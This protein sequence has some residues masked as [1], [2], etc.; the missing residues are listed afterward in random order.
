MGSENRPVL[1]KIESQIP[2]R[3]I[4]STSG[5]WVGVCEPLKLTAQAETWIDLVND[6]AWAME[7]VFEDLLETNDLETFLRE[8]G[9]SAPQLPTVVQSP[10]VKFD[11]PFLPQLASPG[12]DQAQALSL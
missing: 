10:Q 9:W 11:I 2:W 6:I 3:V 4:R 8:R 7:S 5:Y 1:V 12:N